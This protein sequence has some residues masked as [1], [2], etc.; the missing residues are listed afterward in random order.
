M[1]IDEMASFVYKPGQASLVDADRAMWDY[2]PILTSSNI[3]G[4]KAGHGRFYEQANPE[5]FAGMIQLMKNYVNSRGSWM[6][7]TLLSDRKL[8]SGNA[9]DFLHG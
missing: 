1:L 6:D 3:N 7:S 9:D 5:T 8:D 2:N 4:S